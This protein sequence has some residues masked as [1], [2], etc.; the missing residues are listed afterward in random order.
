[1]SVGSSADGNGRDH[2]IHRSVDDGNRV[3]ADVRNIDQRLV[4]PHGRGQRH[5]A[6]RD[7]SW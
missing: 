6:N 7:C 5:H 1:M 3:V 2:G 4:T